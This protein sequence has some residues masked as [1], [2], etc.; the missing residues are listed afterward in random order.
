M[1]EETDSLIIFK[2]RQEKWLEKEIVGHELQK[3]GTFLWLFHCR[4]ILKLENIVSSRKKI[5]REGSLTYWKW[6][7]YNILS[8]TREKYFQGVRQ[9]F[10]FKI[11]FLSHWYC[12]ISM[13]FLCRRTAFNRT[14][15]ELKY[16][17]NSH[18]M[19]HCHLLIVPMWNWNMAF[20]A[21]NI[22]LTILL[23]VPMWNWNTIT[24]MQRL[25]PEDLLIV[26]MWNWNVIRSSI[27]HGNRWLLIVPMWNW[28]E[29]A[30]IF[31][32]VFNPF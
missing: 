20:D 18:K 13:Y 8:N 24:V 27:L 22:T 15:V 21:G 19:D 28:N 29:D 10:S 23:I 7:V 30:W 6:M 31:C 12:W 16:G 14:N 32:V 3:L 11:L 9:L 5:S 25:H 4:Y 26:P 2:T 17:N 1:D